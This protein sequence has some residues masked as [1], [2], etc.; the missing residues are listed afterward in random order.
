MGVN[1]PPAI[2]RVRRVLGGGL[3][4]IAVSFLALFAAILVYALV[5][6]IGARG[7]PDQ[8]AINGFARMLSPAFMPWLERVLTPAVAFWVVRRPAPGSPVDGL[9][10]GLLAGLLGV[11]VTLAFGGVLAIS[12]VAFVVILAVLGWLGGF[13]GTKL[14]APSHGLPRRVNRSG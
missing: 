14:P 7:I 1:R 8:A 4:V 5:L 9:L 6:A 10:I 3:A 11:G 13:V 12:N 2:T